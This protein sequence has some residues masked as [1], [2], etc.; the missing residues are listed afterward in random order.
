MNILGNVNMP[1]CLSD[2][3]KKKNITSIMVT[4]TPHIFT[5]EW[6]ATGYVDFTNGNTKGQQKFKANT[7]DEVVLLIKNFIEQI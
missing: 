1:S 2:P 6:Q 4:Y 5:G 3:F 7:F